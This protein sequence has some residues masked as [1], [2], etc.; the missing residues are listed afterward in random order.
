[1]PKESDKPRTRKPRL[2]KPDATDG[3]AIWELV[4][5]CKPLDENSMYCNLVQTDHFRDTCVVAELGGDIVG[6]IS[7]Y[8]IPDSDDLFVWQVAVSPQARGLGLGR[9]MLRSLTERSACADAT[10]MKTT[11]TKSNEASWALFKAFSRSIGGELVDEPHFE[12]DTHF[13]GQHATEHMVTIALPEP[14]ILAR[15]A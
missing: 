11:I 2:R 1:M 8:M 12:R 14:E 13:E 9:E 4:K 7:G 10:H 3:A 5:S 6:W 15:A